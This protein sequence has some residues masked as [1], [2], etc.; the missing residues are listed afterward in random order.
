M[1]KKVCPGNGCNNLIGMKEKRCATCAGSHAVEKAEHNKKYNARKRN[2]KTAK[3]YASVPWKKMREVV[4][5]RDAHL[6]IN[7]LDKG[8]I[9]SAVLVHHIIETSKTLEFALRKDNLISLC[10]QCHRDVHAAYNVNI[11][12]EQQRL[13]NLLPYD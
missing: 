1:P 8:N 11:E 4:I 7:C 9:Q 2:S 12:K 6:C 13:R 10:D 3:F 5:T